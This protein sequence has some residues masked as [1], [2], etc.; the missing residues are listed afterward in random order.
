MNTSFIK[1][2]ILAP[3]LA[4]YMVIFLPATTITAEIQGSETISGKILETMDAAGYT[5]V[6]LSTVNGTLWV[7]LPQT[8]VSVG[9]E[10]TCKPGMEMQDFH[11]NSF[12]RTFARIIFSEGVVGS[13]PLNPHNLT[14]AQNNA[15]Q[16]DPFEAAVKSEKQASSGT[17]IQP[18]LSSGGSMGAIAPFAEITVEKAEGANA[19]TVGD[20]FDRAQELDGQTIRV[21]GKVVK[22]NANIMGKN[23]LHIQDGTGDP[24][25]NTHDLVI[26]TTQELGS[27]RV[28]TVEGKLVANKDFGAG[29]KY[30]VIIENGSIIK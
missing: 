4:L 8:A 16:E 28:L 29:Y 23:W 19:F 27:P 9:D 30:E 2:F 3:A 26:T 21:R 15:P 25:K 1:H 11:S 22:Y 10:I 5:Y 12:D 6:N 20:L 7:A 14:A 18:Q 24:M 17:Q 13:E